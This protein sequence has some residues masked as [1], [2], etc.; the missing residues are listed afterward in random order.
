[1]KNATLIAL[2]PM[3]YVSPLLAHTGQQIH[4][5]STE[6]S[7]VVLIALLSIAATTLVIKLRT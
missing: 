2:I 3:L 7:L 5:H 4:S 1:M 6:L